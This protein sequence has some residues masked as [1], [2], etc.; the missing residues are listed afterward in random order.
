[1]REKAKPPLWVVDAGTVPYAQALSWQ[2][3][4]AA[5]RAAGAVPDM[6]LLL[7]H[8]AVY[9]AGRRSDPADLPPKETGEEVH[10]VDRGGKVTYHGPG[11]LVGYPILALRQPVDVVGYVRLL[12]QCLIRTAAELGVQAT[13]TPGAPGIWVGE[14]KLASIGVRISR[15][16]TT[17]GFAMNVSTDL[18]AFDSIVACGLRGKT[19]TSLSAL[20]GREVSVRE[21]SAPVGRH[22]AAAL[23]REEI[24]V[25]A[26]ELELEGTHAF[27]G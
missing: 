9:T 20:L 4:L 17:H 5:R 26:E 23:G 1:M 21:V 11:Q 27:A 7:E 8:P 10:W 2:H 3:T 13:R 25:C 24:H 16:I 22:L 14:A 19:A 6:L 18:K 12:E 15:G